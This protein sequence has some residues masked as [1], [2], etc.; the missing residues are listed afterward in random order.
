MLRPWPYMICLILLSSCDRNHRRQASFGSYE[1]SG[2]PPEGT[3]AVSAKPE[4][5]KLNLAALREGQSL[6]RKQC[7][8]CHGPQG[9]GDGVV[10]KKGFRR[11]ESLMSAAVLTKS[12][13]DYVDFLSNG[14]GRMPSFARRLTLAQR[15]KLAHFIKALQLSRRIKVTELDAADRE[16]LR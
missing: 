4:V 15:Y 14:T 8:S 3:S 2:L 6:Y 10:T 9:L 11:T 1:K 13:S 16:R 5:L 12:V 7:L